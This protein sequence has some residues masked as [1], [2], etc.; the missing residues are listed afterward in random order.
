[1]VKYFNKE[2]FWYSDAL[3]LKGLTNSIFDTS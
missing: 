3:L 1:M 2:S